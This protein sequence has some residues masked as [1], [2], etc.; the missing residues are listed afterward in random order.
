MMSKAWRLL[1]FDAREDEGDGKKT[2]IPADVREVMLLRPEIEMPLS[3]D[4]NIWPSH[5]LYYPHFRTVA[6]EPPLIETPRESG[7]DFWLNLTQMRRVLTENGR[8]A[9]L[10]AVE[11]LAPESITFSDFASAN[12]YSATEPVDVLDRS[13]CL[14]FDVADSGFWSGLSN[15]GYSEAER[16]ELRPKW[17]DRINDFGLLKSEQDAIEFRELSDARVPEHA[18]F[19]VFRLSR[20]PDL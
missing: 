12:I 16:A 7:S 1:G 20:L 11:L 17:Q 18:P 10:I 3:V 4:T 9:I 19:W 15:C 14:G 2:P 5:F 6:R 13:I 8:T